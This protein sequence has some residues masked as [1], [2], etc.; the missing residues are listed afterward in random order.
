MC[1]SL[2]KFEKSLSMGRSKLYCTIFAVPSKVYSKVTE[3][4]SVVCIVKRY[5]ILFIKKIVLKMSCKAK[6]NVPLT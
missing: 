4:I 1:V 2:F 6:F 3:K 5:H